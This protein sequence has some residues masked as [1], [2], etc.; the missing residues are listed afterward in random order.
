[1]IALLFLVFDEFLIF[2][3][4]ICTIEAF[5]LGTMFALTYYH[6]LILAFY[7]FGDSGIYHV[8]VGVEFLF[9]LLL[10]IFL[11]L[12]HFIFIFQSNFQHTPIFQKTDLS[13]SFVS[14]C[15]YNSAF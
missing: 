3:L 14:T 5:P 11:L 15:L 6:F 8:P 10:I 13:Y 7:V 1:M 12:H 9:N 2:G 4:E